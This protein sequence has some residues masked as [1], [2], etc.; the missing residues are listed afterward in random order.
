M[1]KKIAASKVFKGFIAYSRM[2]H[3][4]FSYLLTCEVYLIE[5]LEIMSQMLQNIFVLS[6]KPI[7]V[8]FSSVEI[9]SKCEN[10]FFYSRAQP[11]AQG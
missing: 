5:V 7:K 11:Y 10:D 4:F 8:S 2:G 6:L 1:T 3:Y 9:G